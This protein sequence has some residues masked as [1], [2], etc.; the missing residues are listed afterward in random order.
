MVRFKKDRYVIEVVTGS[1]PTERWLELMKE[2]SRVLSLIDPDNFPDDGF[3][4]LANLMEDMLPD[5]ETARKMN[6]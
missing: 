1:E 5:W 2:I 6:G 3:Y 4:N